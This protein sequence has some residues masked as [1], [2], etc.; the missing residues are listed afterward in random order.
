MQRPN[1]CKSTVSSSSVS[2]NDAAVVANPDGKGIL[3]VSTSDDYK[4]ME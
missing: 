2:E 3:L 1:G 4:Y